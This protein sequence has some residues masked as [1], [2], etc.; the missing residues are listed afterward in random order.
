[1][2]NL[3]SLNANVSSKNCLSCSKYISCKDK[4][5]SI[6]H[7]CSQY[8]ETPASKEQS[9]SILFE[10]GVISSL[11]ALSSN[12][13]IS[14]DPS[15]DF[16]IYNV[17]KKVIKKDTLVSPDIK[18]DDSDFRLAPNFFKFVTS[19]KGLQQKPFLEQAIL[20]TI[21]FSEYCPLCSDNKWL[22]RH[23]VD[24]IDEFQDRIQLLRRGVCPKCKS[25]KSELV[26]SKDLNFYSEMA[27]CAGQRSG[28]SALIGM[29]SA[30][31]TH[32]QLMLQNPNEIYGLLSSNILHG[33]F[34]AL[35][36]AQA[37]D[38]LWEPFYGYL[39]DSPFF[40]EYHKMLDHTSHRYG[41][42]LYKLK[43]TFVQY[44]HRK[45]LLYA[46]GPDK[47][48]LRGRTRFIA[49]VDELG[50]FDN[51]ALTTKVKMNANEVYIALERSLLT[52]RA[53]AARLLKKGVDNVPPGYFLNI[54]SPSSARD[55]IME[56]VKKSLN[57]R[58]IFGCLKPTW[59]MNPTIT[60]DD[61]AEEFRNDPV[62]AMRDYGA[63]P[64]LT[65]NPFIS[66]RL[67]VEQCFH[68][69]PN[70]CSIQYANKKAK[71]G[72]ITRYAYFNK[73]KSSGKPSVLAIDGGYSSNS[74]ACAVGHLM[75]GKYPIMDL[76]V[77]IQP[78]PGI[79]LNFSLI[80][81]NIIVPILEQR[82]I[83]MFVA[84][85][86]NSIKLLSD[87]RERDEDLVTKQISIKY[88]DMNL[89]KDYFIDQQINIPPPEMSVDDILAYNHSDY[90]NCFKHYPIAHL[91]LQLLTVQDTGSSVIKGD[92]L[93][94]DLARALMLAHTVL[95]EEEYREYFILADEEIASTIDVTQMAVYRG[96]SGGRSSKNQPALGN[97]S[98]GISRSRT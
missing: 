55:K 4:A 20:G 54:S 84:D 25:R 70:P 8:K 79:P 15:K 89:V 31:L 34:V 67:I 91:V 13:E 42:E 9:L 96:A 44:R 71:D 68:K 69:K 28:K 97:S 5:K 74:F 90:P 85:R 6:L 72:T 12:S 81:T 86:W 52:V 87:A 61:L 88:S 82:N 2:F 1:M 49:S 66:S 93:T 37:R 64:P 50:W 16:D 40:I 18:I 26:Y 36:Y 22:H 76:F 75:D 7:I 46:A 56:L 21:V 83:K 24:S 3:P 53:S 73:I 80:Y 65:S 38:T 43:D 45:L 78:L 98:I 32:W 47:R 14:L 27:V 10:G 19:K 95:L 33:T 58:K 92:Q 51:T 29:M 41:E 39:L 77:E 63:Q 94:D 57:S 30:Y 11:P 60:Q 48:T 35:T 62:A 59:E 23:E 17:I